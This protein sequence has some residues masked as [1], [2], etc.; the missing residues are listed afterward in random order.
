MTASG[1]SVKL[2]YGVLSSE[3]V[4]K[5]FKYAVI[6]VMAILYSAMRAQEPLSLKTTTVYPLIVS[7]HILLCIYVNTHTHTHTHKG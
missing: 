1:L 3:A 5:L 4:P 2:A 7:F 6:Y